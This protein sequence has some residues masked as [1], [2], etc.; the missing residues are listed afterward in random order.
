MID[1]IWENRQPEDYEGRN[2]SQRDFENAWTHRRTCETISIEELMQSGEKVSGEQLYD[3]PDPRAAFEEQMISSVEMERFKARL[4]QQDRD[5]L[6]LR[7][8]GMKQQDIANRVGLKTHGAVSKRIAKL[9]RE[10][11]NF[12]DEQY[13]GFLDKHVN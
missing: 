7:S 11:Q 12:M 8:Q 5:I 6:E 13:D 9:G 10:L 4:S 3:I 2:Q 1:A